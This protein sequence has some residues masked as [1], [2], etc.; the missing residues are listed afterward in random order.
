MCVQHTSLM[1]PG[2]AFLGLDYK[3]ETDMNGDSM[4][5]KFTKIGLSAAQI[6]GAPE[7]GKI[8]GTS[9][10]VSFDEGIT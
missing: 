3:V 6:V 5:D 1:V 9:L 8:K 10:D 7:N 4:A 2:C